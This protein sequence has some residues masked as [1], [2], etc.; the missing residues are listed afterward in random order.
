VNGSRRNDGPGDRLVEGLAEQRADLGLSPRQLGE[1][2]GLSRSTVRDVEQG[3]NRH[4]HTVVRLRVALA[5]VELYGK[6]V[7]PIPDCPQLPLPVDLRVA[8]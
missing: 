6:P 8:S 7:E 5:M 1:L 4:P 2:T 3:R